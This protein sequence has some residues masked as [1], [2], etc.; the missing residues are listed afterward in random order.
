MTAAS[1][2][3][4]DPST[5]G[6]TSALAPYRI[7]DL[8]TSRAWFTGKLLADLGADVIKVEPPGGDP[9]RVKGPYADDVASP[10]NSLEWWAF[11]RGKRSITLDLASADGR[12]LFLQLAARADAVIE[13]FEPGALELLGLGL[14]ELHR[15][16]P[17]LVLTRVTPFGQTGPFAHLKATDLILAAI[18]GPAWMAGDS[19]RPPVRTS[20][21]QYFQHAAAE[22]A[23]HT[24]AALY[25]AAATGQGQQIDVS[26]QLA[27][28]RTPMNALASPHMD[29][30]IMQ[31][32]T[33]GEPLP[34]APYRSIYHCADGNI[35]ATVT[36]G[37]GL[38][39]YRGWLEAEGHPLPSFLTDLK[40]EDFGPTMLENLPPD[41]PQR[42]SEVLAEFFSTRNKQEIAEQVLTHRLMVVPINNVADNYAD[43]QLTARDYFTPV[44]H[45][46]R[47]EDV[48]YPT[49]WAHLTKTPLTAGR[50]APRIGEHNTEILVDELG[51]S[52][53]DMTLYQEAG[54][55]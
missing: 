7:L 37:P 41:F 5:D 22:A 19:D 13:S 27:A 25:H 21:P 34:Q 55:V 15:A 4:S 9:D 12:A 43:V 2:P 32:S 53:A 38:K 29:G 47:D 6:S 35:M 14:D 51:V 26:A 28:S 18:A 24:N 16:N 50:R 40:D 23:L 52:A 3:A 44:A 17:H 20:T 36:F 45:E 42:T 39:G 11:N 8:T 49:V 1:Q 33:F 30:V 31:R 48:L 10:E 54:V 46:G